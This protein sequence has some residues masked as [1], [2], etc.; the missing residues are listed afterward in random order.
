MHL[1]TKLIKEAMKPKLEIA[2]TEAIVFAVAKAKSY[3]KGK[4]DSIKVKLNSSIY[5]NTF[6]CGILNS[7]EIGSKFAVALGVIIGKDKR[8]LESLT[9]E[10]NIAAQKLLNNNEIIIEINKISSEMFIE[11]E[12]K[13]KDEICIV[14]TE[15]DYTNIVEITINDKKIFTKKSK[16]ISHKK[17]ESI[18][19]KYSVKE[20]LEYINNVNIDEINF[21]MNAYDLNILLFQEGL[22]SKKT[23][24]VKQLWKIN[25]EKIFSEN[26][27]NTAQLLCNGAIEARVLG[28]NKPAM[29]IIDSGIYG[30]ITTLPILA[31]CRVKGLSDEKLMRAT[32][33]SYLIC[34]YIKEYSGSL[35]AFCSCGIAGGTG[36]ACAIGYLRG[37]KLEEITNIINNMAAG[38]TGMICDGGNQGCTMKGIVT[39][40][41]AFRAVDMAMNNTYIF[42]VHGINGITP[43]KTMNNMGK[44]AS[45]DMVEIEKVIIDIFK[46]K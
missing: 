46:D 24:F 29:S 41:T 28:L 20:I 34:M 32:I 1:L 17:K 27:L 39:I 10:D 18:L 31:E 45:P 8:G 23:T 13:T 25:G 16:N 6:T 44:I 37:A 38:I 43:E 11:V 30:I 22:N 19:H 7:N 9:K 2:E 26:S 14:R 12:I 15:E 40:D 3:V 35:S 21:V 33:L 36:V 42:N 5:K 4:I